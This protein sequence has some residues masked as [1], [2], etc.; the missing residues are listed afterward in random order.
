MANRKAQVINQAE[1]APLPQAPQGAF[2]S[3]MHFIDEVQVLIKAGD[4]G[5]GCISFL[6]E[7]YRPRGG[8]AGGNGGDGGSVI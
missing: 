6:R 3:Y 8:P 4:G 1:V 5:R 2:F 7:K